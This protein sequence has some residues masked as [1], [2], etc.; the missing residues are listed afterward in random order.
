MKRIRIIAVMIGALL[1][2]TSAVADEKLASLTVNGDT[3]TNVIVTRVT[4]T[5]IYFT[6][7]KGMGNAKLRKLDPALQKH[8]GFNAT[9][10]TETEQKQRAASAQFSAALQARP[11]ARPTGNSTT[12]PDHSDDPVVPKL[13]AKSFRGKRPPQIVVPE[14]ITPPPNLEGKFVLVDFWATWCGPCRKSI[15]HLNS[16]AARFK[17]RLVVIG[18]GDEPAAEIR[19]MTNPK[20]EYF[21]GTDPA[22]RTLREAGVEGIPHA[23]LMDPHGIVRFEGMPHYL[24][25][26]ALDRLIRKYSD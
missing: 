23:L 9:A 10:A 8:F 12:P 19:K 24:T 3:Y 7:A 18:L 20:I 21:V 13:Y 11:A 2:V 22:A 14:W 5:D 16:L 1:A 15:P 26:D 25:E 17:D 4:A 6:H